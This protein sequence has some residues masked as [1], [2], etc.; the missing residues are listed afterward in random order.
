MTVSPPS[1]KSEDLFRCS[2]SNQGCKYVPDS[3][4]FSCYCCFLLKISTLSIFSTWFFKFTDHSLCVTLTREALQNTSGAPFLSVLGQL[5][6]IA[7]VIY[8]SQANVIE[9]KVLFLFWL[10]ILEIR[11]HNWTGQLVWHLTHGLTTGYMWECL[12]TGSQRKC[13]IF[14]SGLCDCWFHRVRHREP[15]FPPHKA[16]LPNSSTPSPALHPGHQ[17]SIRKA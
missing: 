9:K 4:L 5:L 3:Q 8:Y 17:T 6:F 13:P 15:V 11:S 16:P 7:A 14:N 1:Y 12:S 2:G 10:I